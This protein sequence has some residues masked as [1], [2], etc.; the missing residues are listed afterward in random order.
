MEQDESIDFCCRCFASSQD[1]SWGEICSHDYCFNCGAGGFVISIPVWA[2]KSIR[3]S[4]SFVGKRYYPDKEDYEH[5]T[6][7]KC[8]IHLLKNNKQALKQKPIV[9]EAREILSKYCI[10]REGKLVS[11]LDDNI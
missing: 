1:G 10:V 6:I 2:I 7:K 11:I 9:K 4:A 5:D 8:C 3:E